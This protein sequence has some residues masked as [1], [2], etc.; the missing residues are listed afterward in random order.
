MK[1]IPLQYTLFYTYST[2]IIAACF[3]LSAL[4]S[5]IELPKQKEI[6]FSALKRNCGSITQSMDREFDRMFT[7]SLDIAY[8]TLVRGRFAG[9]RRTFGDSYYTKEGDAKVL[10]NLLG[11]LIGPNR[12]AD[13]VFLY[14]PQN[15][16]VASG[17]I[18]G[19]FDGNAADQPWFDYLSKTSKSKVMLYTDFDADLARYFTGMYGKHF[20]SAT[21]QF[22]D[23][24]NNSQGYVCIKKS[25]SKVISAALE[26][27]SLYG[28]QIYIYD[29]FGELIYPLGVTPPEDFFSY[30]QAKNFPTEITKLLSASTDY[31][32]TCTPSA[33]S[34]FITVMAIS[35]KAVFSPVYSYILRIVLIALGAIFIFLILTYIAAKRITIPLDKICE[36]VANFSFSNPEHPPVLDIKTT[37]LNVLYQNFCDMRYRL[38]K[39]LKKQLLLQNQETQSRMLALQSQ[40]NPHFLYNSLASI[41]A[42]ADENK[43]KDIVNMC[44]YMANILRYISS[45]SEQQ[46]SLENEIKC[47][48]D[49]LM[50]MDLRYQGDLSYSINIPPEM[51]DIKVPKLCVQILVENAV[52]F[53]SVNRPPYFISIEGEKG[54]NYYTLCI[55]DNG[56]GFTEESMKAINEK[57]NKINES[58][59]LPSLAI[60]GM[61]IINVYIRYKLLH[62][63][64]II[65]RIG[66][67]LPHGAC[68]T[69]GAFL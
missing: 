67:H 68:I 12:L 32:Y 62:N 36:E 24:F 65:F 58:G 45:D 55:K 14:S 57:I 1:K 63:K 38:I 19:A 4:F 6:V 37:E 3:A 2:V 17:L 44:Q 30:A 26:Y 7:L 59:L 20:V 46:I 51:Y 40:I 60:N 43:N 9:S 18:N 47:T 21:M 27:E 22:F 39:S 16:V 34:D 35:G 64:N 49:Y 42:M 29:G 61:G 33:K 11:A 15:E 13:Q 41:Q 25:L 50:C 10:E 23:T 5:V 8:S 48:K 69:I 66:N 28:E 54:D 31:Y 53:A 56:P 52:K